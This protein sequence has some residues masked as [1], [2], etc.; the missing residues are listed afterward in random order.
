[1]GYTTLTKRWLEDSVLTDPTSI[2]LSDPTGTYG[3]KRNDTDVVIVA[4]GTDMTKLSTGVYSYYWED[5][6]TGLTYT[7][8]VEVTATNGEVHHYEFVIDGATVADADYDLKDVRS[9]FVKDTGRYDLIVN[10]DIDANVDNGAN[11]HINNAQRWLDLNPLVENPKSHLRYMKSVSIGDYSAE[12]QDLIDVTKVSF[13]DSDEARSD[14]TD[15]WY[16]PVTFRDEIDEAI[17]EW[18]SGDPTYW[19]L[20]V[21]GLAPEQV[22]ETAVT[23]AAAG[24]QDYDDIHFE[25]HWRYNGILWYPKADAAL[26]LDL[27]GHFLSPRLTQDTDVSFWTRNYPELLALAS[28]Y[29]LERSLRNATGMM[30]WKEAMSELLLGI[31]NMAV[32]MGMSGMSMQMEG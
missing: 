4:D 22:D 31:D 25:D 13:V 11:L 19:T 27:W 30:Q 10:G 28:A 8:Y 15:N 12:I 21:I 6:T 29:C 2:K 14:I 26:T 20:N 9:R 18:D 17:S 5:P 32:K 24:I 3:V 16:D 7:A 1:M 23:F